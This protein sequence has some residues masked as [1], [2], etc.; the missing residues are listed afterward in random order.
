MDL[1]QI[2][3][4]LGGEVVGRQVLAPGP[5]HSPRDRSLSVW[6]SWQAPLGFTTFSH[7]GDDFRECRD[8]VAAKLG[9][10]TDRTNRRRLSSKVPTSEPSVQ[11]L[12]IFDSADRTRRAVELWAEGVDPRGT[13]A[14]S[15]LA[16]RG[17]ALDDDIAG[18]VLRYHPRCP[19]EKERT[20][21]M[22]AGLRLIAGDQVVAIQRTKLAPDGTK[23]GRMT[24]APSTGAAVK[25]DR[26][27]DVT[28]GL[29]LAEGVET[30]LAA[31]A[32]GLRPV[33]ATCGRSGIAGFPVLPGIEAITLLAENDE[34]NAR[35]VQACAERW[36]GAGREVTVI[37]PLI[38]NDLNDAI[39]GAA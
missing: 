9:L 28:T 19:W 1:R 18:R 5:G 22:I 30:A 16:S 27:E 36:H 17:L 4:A 6:L 14:E 2:A 38:G 34:P 15:Y 20:P 35:A 13:P 7:A 21:G 37:E 8:Y 23:L 10:G 12:H 33:W 26:D 31:R 25:L 39:R 24:L 29:F 32:M 3:H 11:S